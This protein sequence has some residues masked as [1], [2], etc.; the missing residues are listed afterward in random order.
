MDPM[1]AVS[2]RPSRLDPGMIG[3]L[4]DTFPSHVEPGCNCELADHVGYT[5]VLSDTVQGWKAGE[6][7]VK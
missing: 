3:Y 7:M 2:A 5:S 6:E 4:G 1:P